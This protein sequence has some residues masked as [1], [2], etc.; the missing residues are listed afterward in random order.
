MV[1]SLDMYRDEIQLQEVP[2]KSIISVKVAVLNCTEMR[3]NYFNW[4]VRVVVLTC[5]G[6]RY[7]NNGFIKKHQ[8]PKR[9]IYTSEIMSSLAHSSYEFNHFFALNI[10][11]S[12]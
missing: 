6:K 5:T 1:V 2:F 11:K 10:S 4:I 7:K 3:S 12:H 9:G 8:V